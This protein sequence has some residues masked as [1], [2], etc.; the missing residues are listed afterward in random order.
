METTAL[1]TMDPNQFDANQFV[2]NVQNGD[3]IS[4]ALLIVSGLIIIV[5]IFAFFVSIILSIKYVKYNKQMNSANLSG[6]QAARKILDAN[7]LQDIKVKVTGSLMFGNSYSHYFKKVRLR[8]RT[9][10]KPSIA[11]LAMAAQKSSLAVLDKEGDPD[12]KKRVKLT[13]LNVLGPLAFIPLVIIGIALDIVIN[14]TVGNLAIIFAGVGFLFY[15]VSFL[16]SIAVLKTEKKAQEKAVEILLA[17][18]M[19]TPD[20]VEDMK[21]LFKLYNI[22]YVNNLILSMLEMLYYVLRI[23]A[24]FQGKGNSSNKK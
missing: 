16:F 3:P 22:E 6:E 24:M 13:I 20:E 10:K 23:I 18:H 4:I 9:V 14:N 15:L 17:E 19:A 12:M 11:S 1:N 21:K 8:R 7:D 5:S 2:N